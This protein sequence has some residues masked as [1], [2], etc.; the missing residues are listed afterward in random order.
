[1]AT[2]MLFDW[3]SVTDR[4]SPLLDAQRAP[5]TETGARLENCRVCDGCGA[6]DGDECSACAGLGFDWGI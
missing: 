2:T 4:L 3:R 5:R 6:V 1:M